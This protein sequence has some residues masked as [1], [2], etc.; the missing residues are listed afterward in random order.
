MHIVSTRILFFL[1]NSRIVSCVHHLENVVGDVQLLF[2]VQ[3]T[4]LIC[5]VQN[6]LVF[7]VGVVEFYTSVNTVN[8]LVKEFLLFHSQFLLLLLL[9][10]V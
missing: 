3:Y 8:Q 5:I 4:A 9:F 1:L 2:G 6:N 10:G 7:A